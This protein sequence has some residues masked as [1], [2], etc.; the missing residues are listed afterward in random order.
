MKSKL[1]F[2][3]CFICMLALAVA[4]CKVKRP[5]DVIP[6]SKMESLLYDYHLA[7]S[8]GDNLPYSENYKKALY[9]D[10][11]FKKYGTTQAVFDSSMVWY[12]RNTEV[13]SK[14]YEK[15][16]EI[17]KVQGSV[18]GTLGNFSASIG[19]AKSK[20]T[21]NVSAIVAASL[22][23]GTVLRYVAELPENKR[24]VLYV[25]TE[26]SHYHCLK[27]MKRILRLA[28]L[29]DDRDNEHLEFL[30][31]RKYTPEQRIRI[32]EQA[33]YNTPDI[34]LVIIDGIRD[35]VYDINSPGESTRIISKLMQWTDDR[36]IH[37]HTI[38]H[39]NK[40]DENARGHIGTELNNKA[41]TVLLVEKDKSNGDISN[42][43][44]M[45]IRA[46]DFEPFA[47]RINDNALPELIEGYRPEAK[48][49]GRPEEEKFDPYRHITEQQHRI[50]LEA[51][52][53]LKEEYG[54]KDL[55]TALVKAY[56]S[57]GVKL[58]HQKAVSLITMLRNKRM[59]V[60]ENGRKYTFKPDFHY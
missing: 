25:D 28:G 48:K 39:Q 53:G 29:P 34:G 45:H 24:K 60:Q 52:F 59:I 38:L 3:L 18:I 27:V 23:N 30:A 50:A 57:V 44:A 35:M 14:I 40:G 9:I 19:K 51:A 5:N 21:F 1:R 41:E 11:V 13:L 32:V 56:M 6:E 54:Y 12:T 8:M 42:V 4:G 55:E 58:N 22:K 47:F 2:H 20:K 49:P 33:I 17:L 7:K 16:P 10:A 15:A 26:Q 46:M 37:I 31:L 36:Q 43:S